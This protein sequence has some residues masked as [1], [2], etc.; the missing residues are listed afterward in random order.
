MTTVAAAP[1]ADVKTIAPPLAEKRPRL[2][3]AIALAAA[4]WIGRAI[5]TVFFPG[6]FSL[7][8]Y[9]F[10]SPMVLGVAILLW[11]L[12]LSRMT[13]A[14]RGWSAL[15]LIGG[16]LAA[17]A[18]ADKT[19]QFGMLMYALPVAVTALAVWMLASRPHGGWLNRLALAIVLVAAW[20]Y[21]TMIRMDGIDGALTPE[22]S[23]RWDETAEQRFLAKQ[24][25]ASNSKPIEL[26]T[27]DHDWPA[28]RGPERDGV[29][30]GIQISNDWDAHPP[31][32]LWRKLVGPNWSSIAVIGDYG[33][34]QEQRGD[35][36]AV[37][38]FEIKT[39][40]EVWAHQAPARFWEVVAGAGPRATPTF[41]NGKLYAQGA[42][43]RLDCLDAAT[44]KP[45]WTQDIAKDANTKP[46][47]WGFSGSPLLVQGVVIT[48]A[49]GKGGKTLL[50][51]DAETGEPRWQAGEGTHSY[52]S[53][54]PWTSNGEEQV[55]LVSDFGLQSF[56]PANGKVLWE[57]KWFLEGM[58]RVVQ[59]LITDDS[60][61]L[62]GTGMGNGTRQVKVHPASDGKWTVE[63]GW[64]SK[65]I[66]P[67]FNDYVQHDGH[68]YGFDGDIFTCI[69]LET[70]ERTWK[71]GRYGNG[72]ALLV[73]DSGLLLIVTEN[74]GELVLL[75][76]NPDE[77]IE[78]AKLKALSGK[79]WNH[80]VLTGNKLLVRNGEEMAC[81]E[82]AIEP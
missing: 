28:F 58:F 6:T 64:T 57:N 38:C 45:L 20:G 52:S 27:T 54:H 66:K 4:Y 77:H 16:G 9:L 62:V 68:L 36:E 70:G 10:W 21:F 72:Q 13:W 74:T 78:L 71:K 12:I 29:V 69:D 15:W 79:T 67:Y 41:D 56:D 11:L 48:Y 63:E 42:S 81:Y 59:P 17:S 18:L 3:P 50:A 24:A 47:Q 33:F 14:D 49:G 43:G 76:A 55:L 25:K 2:W 30:R 44:G 39:G 73:A 80:P 46:P 19:M 1:S 35:D 8:L 40:K 5:L 34:T 75:E 51:Y 60:S 26:I 23:W 53:P 31:R 37:V 61:I 82:L 65:D 7:F 32:E 22:F